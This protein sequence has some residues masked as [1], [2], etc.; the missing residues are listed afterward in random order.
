ME[1]DQVRDTSVFARDLA[2]GHEIPER[3]SAH[4]EKNGTDDISPGSWDPRME[5]SSKDV[6]GNIAD[7]GLRATDQVPEQSSADDDG[8]N[9]EALDTLAFARDFALQKFPHLEDPGTDEKFIK[10]R[11]SQIDT[12]WDR[13]RG[14]AQTGFRAI[15][16]FPEPNFADGEGGKE[17]E[18][19]IYQ[20]HHDSIVSERGE[21]PVRDHT[22]T[23]VSPK[24]NSNVMSVGFDQVDPPDIP[25][26]ARCCFVPH[27]GQNAWIPKEMQWKHPNLMRAFVNLWRH[28]QRGYEKVCPPVCRPRNNPTAGLCVGLSEKKQIMNL[29]GHDCQE[30]SDPKGQRVLL[31]KDLALNSIDYTVCGVDS[32]R[33]S[34]I[35]RGALCSAP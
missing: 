16:E 13:T 26:K 35:F 29:S 23:D 14:N 18:E 6:P 25:A 4:L 3:N 24:S 20:N 12:S 11:D 2:P 21:S 15:D 9:V 34:R 28:G 10:S 7:T 1:Q 17:E 33:S 30:T 32:G 5:L 27:I 8:G 31:P 19:P 22:A